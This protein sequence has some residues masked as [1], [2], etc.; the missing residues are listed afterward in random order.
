MTSFYIAPFLFVGILAPYVPA[1]VATLRE[2][3]R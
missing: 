2:F 3:T 1:I